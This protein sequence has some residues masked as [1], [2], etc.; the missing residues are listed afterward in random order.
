MKPSEEIARLR[1]RF[2]TK[3]T[4]ERAQLMVL[5]AVVEELARQ[6]ESQGEAM[7]ATARAV[8]TVAAEVE[9]EVH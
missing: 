2:E 1:R 6:V 8:G 5:W 3:P 4:S 7:C 9:E